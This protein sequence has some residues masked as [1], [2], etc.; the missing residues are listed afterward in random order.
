MP[1]N[2]TSLANG[3]TFVSLPD[4]RF[5]TARLTVGMFLPLREDTAAVYALLPALLSRATAA[6]PDMIAMHRR[7]SRL[8]GATVTAGAQRLGDCQLLTLTVQCID[9]R[10][11]LGGEDV[12]QDAAQ[13]LLEMLF[14]PHLA[15]D[16]LWDANDVEQ[17]KRCLLERIAAQINDKREYAHFKAEQML[18]PADPYSVAV[19]GTPKTAAAITRVSVTAAW[20]TML[21]EAQFYW[22]YAAADSGEG[23]KAAIGDAFAAVS[24]Q[25]AA[26]ETVPA[27]SVAAPV[28]ATEQMPVAQAKLT[29]GFTVGAAEPDA[30][31][32]MAA[33]LFTALFGGSPSSLLFRNVRE[34]MSLCYYC[35]ATFD[36]IK[37]VLTVDSGVDAAKASVAERAILEQLQTIKDGAFSEEDLETA[38]LYVKN[39]L[40]ERENSQ[41]GILYWHLGQSLSETSVTP[42]EAVALL[43]TVTAAEVIAVAKTLT[44]GSVFALLPEGEAV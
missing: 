1:V 25:T 6:S 35:R 24:R 16:G 18:C 29:L 13:L 36:R 40:L 7:L 30:R 8:Y 41:G 21:R 26:C 14:S 22:F 3:V 10:F 28:R 32:V 9:N 12:A 19:L 23:V 11:T 38:R 39:A 27:A 33:R 43:E 2:K 20:Q 5:K 42:H 34:K 44:L 4:T 31:A 17:E 37:G 15:A